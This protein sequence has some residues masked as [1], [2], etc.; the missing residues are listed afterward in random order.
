MGFDTNFILQDKLEDGDV[1]FSDYGYASKYFLGGILPT[2]GSNRFSF[3]GL[4]EDEV[5]ASQYMAVKL[6]A[7]INP[8]GKIYLTPH[9]NIA[10]VGFG[11]F[12]EYI[13]EAFN[14]K[15]NWD[16]GTETSLLLSGGAAASYLS[17][18]GP[19]HFDV[20][21]VNNIDKVRLFFSV[22]LSLNP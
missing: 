22:G 9:F 15:G 3:P 17:I 14:P 1:S 19:I 4:H 18:L 7:Q 16:N 12:N 10:T 21:W 2:S 13:G 8:I 20:S 11:N 5:N 6:G